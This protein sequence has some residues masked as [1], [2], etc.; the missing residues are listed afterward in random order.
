MRA[1]QAKKILRYVDGG[2]MHNLSAYWFRRILGY[3]Y[4]FHDD[5]RILEALRIYRKHGRGIHPLA[6][7]TGK[8]RKIKSMTD[9][10]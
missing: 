6:E 10:N 3:A 5:H 7:I 4:C 9:T 8:I 2:K 1:R